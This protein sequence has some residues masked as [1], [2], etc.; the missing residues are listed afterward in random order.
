VAATEMKKLRRMSDQQPGYSALREYLQWMADLP[1]STTSVSPPLLPTDE[2]AEATAAATTTNRELLGGAATLTAARA[3]L[4]RDHH[5]L[6][7]VKE[8]IVQYLAVRRLRGQDGRAP[9]LCLAGP[10]GVG[11]TSLAKSIASVLGRPFC[12][13]CLVLL[14]FRFTW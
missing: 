10:P 12:R 2:V 13:C 5:G 6:Q 3:T 11:K 7:R 1:W 8:R 4:D 9:I 14:L